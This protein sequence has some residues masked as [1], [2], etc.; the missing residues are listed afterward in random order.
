MTAILT[1]KDLVVYL[2]ANELWTVAFDAM[3]GLKDVN[4]MF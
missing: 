3:N 4:L 1:A 2:I